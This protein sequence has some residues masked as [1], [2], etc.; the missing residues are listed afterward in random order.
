MD[1]LG[2]DEGEVSGEVGEDFEAFV[3][4]GEGFVVFF[5]SGFIGF[6]GF[7]SFIGDSFNIGVVFVDFVIV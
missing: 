3:D 2:L 5:N 1:S 6:V 7:F 4:G